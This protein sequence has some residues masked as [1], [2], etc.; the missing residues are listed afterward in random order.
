[1]T[2]GVCDAARNAGDTRPVKR[3]HSTLTVSE[4][5]LCSDQSVDL[6][7]HLMQRPQLKLPSCVFRFHFLLVTLFSTALQLELLLSDWVSTGETSTHSKKFN[8]L[9][10]LKFLRHSTCRIHCGNHLH[11]VTVQVELKVACQVE[12]FNDYKSFLFKSMWPVRKQ[13]FTSIK[14]KNSTW[15]ILIALKK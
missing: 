14:I 4:S 12:P 1:M 5:A 6:W 15:S 11:L 8:R 7:Q 3:S 13:K 2:D 9:N 10:C